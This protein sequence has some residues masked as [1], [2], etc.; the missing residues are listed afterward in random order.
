MLRGIVF[1]IVLTVVANPSATLLC[2]Q[3]C[4]DQTAR[5]DACD[6]HS[7]AMSVIRPEDETCDRPI[8]GAVAWLRDDGHRLTSASVWTQAVL[9]PH[10]RLADSADNYRAHITQTA[11]RTLELR[12]L[13]ALRI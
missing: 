8:L 13:S 2:G 10:D 6:R 12:P 4:D 5:S 1:L 11:A 7:Q 9:G 3:R